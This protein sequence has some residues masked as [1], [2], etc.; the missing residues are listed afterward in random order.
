M[1]NFSDFIFEHFW[2]TLLPAAY[3]ILFK[4]PVWLSIII[5][6]L[7]AIWFAPVFVSL[8]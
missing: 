6:I 1:G 3:I 4:L 8:K 2:I 7:S 5:V